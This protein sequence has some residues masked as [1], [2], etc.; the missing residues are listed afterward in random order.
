ME[1][2]VHLGFNGQ[3]KE[4]FQFYEKTFHGKIAMIMTYGESPAAAQT[5]PGFHDKVMH[6]AIDFGGQR[7]TGA[8]APPP[9]YQKPQ[10][11]HV[12]LSLTEPAEADRIFQAL[13]ADGVVHMPMEETFW[14]HRFGMVVDRFGTPWMVN[15]SKP[16]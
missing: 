11:I 6:A 12:L 16:M 14:A 5:D 3:C 7:L 4:A 9:R 2:N 1:L 10:G 15:C 8:D 13:S